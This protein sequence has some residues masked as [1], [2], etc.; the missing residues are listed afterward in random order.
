[1]EGCLSMSKTINAKREKLK[2]LAALCVCALC[3]SLCL[4]AIARPT[5]A[6]VALDPLKDVPA[7]MSAWTL[8]YGSNKDSLGNTHTNSCR[9]GDITDAVGPAEGAMGFAYYQLAEKYVRFSGRLACAENSAA[10]A[11]MQLKLYGDSAATPLYVSPQIKADT[12]AFDFTADVSGVTVLRM[13][14]VD[15]QGRAYTRTS[16]TLLIDP[17][18]ETVSTPPISAP[19][20]STTAPGTSSSTAAPPASTVPPPVYA[21][22]P[23]W[24]G[25]FWQSNAAQPASNRFVYSFTRSPATDSLNLHVYAKDLH[26]QVKAAGDITIDSIYGLLNNVQ[27]V[28]VSLKGVFY[29]TVM[30]T[31]TLGGYTFQIPYGRLMVYA[32]D[33][34]YT[35]TEAFE[36]NILTKESIA[37]IAG[38]FGSAAT[39]PSL[40]I[41]TPTSEWLLKIK[42][43][44]LKSLEPEY[45]VNAL[46]NNVY[47]LLKRDGTADF[48]KAIWAGPDNE[49][50][51]ADDRA[52]TL[53]DGSY[54]YEESVG[55]W[56]FVVS[57]FDYVDPRWAPLYA[58]TTTAAPT[59][60]A[61]T[62]SGSTGSVSP[63][64]TTE[65]CYLTTGDSVIPPKTGVPMSMGL[66]LCVAALFM[67]CIYC[68]YRLFRRERA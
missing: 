7:V 32:Q 16:F 59:T 21:P 68:G 63:T 38:M 23:G 40:T 44:I 22:V 34:L 26:P 57:R 24:T 41:I 36:K 1:M 28:S 51:T 20:T 14:L 48:S 62:T 17:M 2:W 3:F 50:G 60:T 12:Q 5:Y 9:L 49:I 27:L 64:T 61:A 43:D 65:N 56:K 35:I 47:L 18:L 30:E 66:L 6:A 29:P 55:V 37:Q 11:A 53:R 58:V 25:L 39:P 31:I 8:T 52:L 45:Y 13:E 54:F 46:K 33:R 15:A 4:G 67:A 19:Y 42:E 10:D